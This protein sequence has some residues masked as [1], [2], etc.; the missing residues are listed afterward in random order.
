MKVFLGV[1]KTKWSLFGD[2]WLNRITFFD[3]NLPDSN[4]KNQKLCN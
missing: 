1:F 4:G 2:I 3:T